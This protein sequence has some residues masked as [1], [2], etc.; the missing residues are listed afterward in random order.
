MLKFNVTGDRLELIS[1]FRSF[2]SGSKGYY[3]AEFTFDS[4]WDGLIPHIVV[5]ENGTQRADEIIFN[6][7]FKIATTENGVMQIGVYGLDAE[8]NKCIS[9][10]FVCLEVR[11]GAYTGEISMPKDIWDGY[12]IVVLGHV[13]RAE[14]AAADAKTSASKAEKA[15]NSIKNLSVTATEGNEVTVTQTET[16]DGMNLAFTLP[17]GEQGP[18]GDRGEQGIQGEQGPQ[19]I[20]GEKGEQGEPGADGRDGYTPIRGANY[21]TDEDKA[22]IKAYVDEAILGGAW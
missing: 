20:P 5:I 4:N 18:K 14:G 17:R 6:N 2:N 15:A 19:G 21:W 13:N 9:S 10:D 22:E 11:S 3:T 12:Q 1:P 16:D 7:T 8:G